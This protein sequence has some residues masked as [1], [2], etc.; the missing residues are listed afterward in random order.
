MKRATILCLFLAVVVSTAISA[1]ITLVD[2]IGGFRNAQACQLHRGTLYILDFH[3]VISYDPVSG[4]FLDTLNLAEYSRDIAFMGDRAVVVGISRAHLIDISDPRNMAHI[5]AEN[6]GGTSGWDVDISGNLVFLAVQSH[7]AIYRIIEDAFIWT[8]N[9]NP[10]TPFP[11]VRSVAI[12]GTILYAG[13]GDIGI[14]ALDVSSPASP[15]LIAGTTTPGSTLD[16]QVASGNILVCSDGAYVGSDTTSVRFFDITSHTSITPRGYWFAP[17]DSDARKSFIVGNR[18][19]LADGEGGIRAI[20]FSM[21]SSP[22]EIAHF[23]TRDNITDVFVDG[24]DMF[25]SGTDTLYLLWTDAFPSD[26]GEPSSARITGVSP[27]SGT[28]TACAPIIEFRYTLGSS[29]INAS[30]IQIEALGRIFHGGDSEISLTSSAVL[31]DLSGETID[32]HDT[33]CARLVSMADTEGTSAIGLGTSTCF[34]ID[35][36]PPHIE[37]HTGFDGDT[38]KP[39]SI[40][41]TGIIHNVGWADFVTDSFRVVVNGISYSTAGTFLDYDPPNFTCS[42]MGVFRDGDTVEVCV[43]AIDN[44]LTVN[45]GP[46]RLDTCWTFFVS[47]TN[48]A[49]SQQTPDFLEINAS[50]NPFNSAVKFTIEHP[51][52]ATHASPM[53]IQIFDL[54]GRCIETFPVN[55]THHVHE[56]IWQPENDIATG[57]YLVRVKTDGMSTTKP[58]IYLK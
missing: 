21:P 13:L 12:D 54:A 14:V 29:P 11:M 2:K 44:V 18:L 47:S 17:S 27:E 49:E 38:L 28:I 8:S 33:L 32:T 57:I 22:I 40:A 15:S 30:S 4:E 6:F 31:L 25:A 51:A 1:E 53:Q 37:I 42:P 5:T 35:N 34:F 43:R 48:I 23:P 24:N 56:F 9:Y 16:L 58:I 7:V 46:N 20:D 39:D 26:T 41:I 52:C 10:M 55:K 45:C 36:F 3:Y 19:A 50:P